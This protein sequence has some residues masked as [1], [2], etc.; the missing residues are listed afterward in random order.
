MKVIA[1]ALLM[2]SCASGLAIAQ[3]AAAPAAPIASVPAADRPT[4]DS[5]RQLMQIQKTQNVLEQV[6]KQVDA[7]FTATLNQQLQ[8]KTLSDDDRQRI[9]AAR[10]RL[11][12]IIGKWLTWESMEPMYLKIYGDTFS[13]SEIDSMIAFYSSPAGQAVVA[14]LPLVAQNTIAAMHEQ[15]KSL[16]PQV[17]QIAKDAATE[18]NSQH[19]KGAK[20][21]AG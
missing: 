6:A 5:I 8:N 13:Q 18:I 10:A 4:D 12:A 9:E 15:M 3:Q 16:M 19:S 21:S 14:K 2:L 17:Q 20:P 7:Q 1:T 11:K